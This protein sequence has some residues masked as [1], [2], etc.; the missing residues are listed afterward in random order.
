MEIIISIL[1]WLGVLTP[2]AITQSDLN[3]LVASHQ[4]RISVVQSD[5]VLLGG[6]V[7]SQAF[8]LPNVSI[9]DPSK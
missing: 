5:T 4:D 7:D 1:L 6:V 9:I 2:G 8:L 3:E